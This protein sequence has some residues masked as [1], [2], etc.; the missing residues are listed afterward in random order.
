MPNS[1]LSADDDI[2]LVYDGQCP[3]CTRYCAN[4]QVDA[5]HGRL[6]H[7]DARQPSAVKREINA[8]GLDLDEGMVLKLG[9]NLYY[10]ADALQ[11]LALISS[12]SGFF[13]RLNAWIFKS[14]RVSRWLYPLLRWG[15]NLLLSLRGK[16]KINNLNDSRN[17]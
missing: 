7:V 5:V 17:T 2:L 11:V 16:S 4:L 15:R 6:R 10:G 1:T 12:K 8:R 3:L 9:G 13:N 14:K